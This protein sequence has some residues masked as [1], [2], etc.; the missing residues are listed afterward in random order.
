MSFKISRDAVHAIATSVFMAVRW[1]NC[2]ELRFVR[3]RPNQGNYDVV[4][5][6]GEMWFSFCFVLKNLE[7]FEQELF[8]KLL[9]IP[10]AGDVADD[11]ELAFSGTVVLARTLKE[12]PQT[13]STDHLAMMDFKAGV[14]ENAIRKALQTSDLPLGE[15]LL[16]LKTKNSF[17]LYSNAFDVGDMFLGTLLLVF[18]DLVDVKWV[19]L[20]LNKSQ[21]LLRVSEGLKGPITM[22]NPLTM[23]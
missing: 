3:Y 18:G 15:F 11:L 14:D 12:L 1:K 21:R 17:H 9:S 16:L 7:T 19:G 22:L 5:G 2:V 23:Y 4:H 13:L 8:D 6:Y 20:A 10:F